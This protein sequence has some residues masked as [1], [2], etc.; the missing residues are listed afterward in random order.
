MAQIISAKI[1]DS[2]SKEPISFASIRIVNTLNGTVANR[3]GHFII[4]A[5]ALSTSMVI[6]SIGYE[7]RTLDLKNIP[8]TIYLKPHRLKLVW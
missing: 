5:D 6:S 1:L 2:Q 4:E 7:S 3:Q 8:Q